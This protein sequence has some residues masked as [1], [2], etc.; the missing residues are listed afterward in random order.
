LCALLSSGGGAEA[1]VLTGGTPPQTYA[2]PGEQFTALAA[3]LFTYSKTDLT[4]AGPMPISVTRVYRSEDKDASGNFVAR[5][6]GL[7]TRLNYNLFLY[8]NSE[9]AYGIYTDAQVI[10]P[11]GARISCQRTSAC[12][13]SS[14]T[15][16][17]NAIFTCA[18]QPTG[19][20]FG[21][22]ISYNAATPG[23]DLERKDGTV[24]AFGLGAPLQS[25]ADRYGNQL[26]ITH[27]SGQSGKI[28]RVDSSNG[29]YVT[30]AY[31]DA[32]NPNAIT[33][34][35]DNSGRTVQYDYNL[36][37]KLKHAIYASF[38]SN[39]STEYEW[40][41]APKEGDIRTIILNV[42]GPTGSIAKNFNYIT[43]QTSGRLASVSSQL[44][45]SGYQYSYFG[46]TYVS[47]VNVTLPDNSV[48][49]LLF[50]S[51]G[52]VTDDR[53]AF[54]LSIQ[55]NTSYIRNANNLVTSMTDPLG[56]QTSY[57][58]DG[59]GNVTSVTHTP[60]PGTTPSATTTYTYEPAF[61]RVASI[62]APLTPPTTMSYN[63]ASNPTSAT[64]TDPVGRTTTL[65]Y[66]ASGQVASV[67]DPLGNT[68]I[69]T[70]DLTSGDQRTVTDPLGN[71]T[72]S[73]TDSV[74][75]VTSVTT[76]LG[77]TTQYAYDALDHVTSVTDP[78]GKVTSYEYI[79]L[80]DLSKVTDARGNVTTITVGA[81]LDVTTVCDA[82][83]HC[84]TENRNAM[85]RKTN[86]FDKRNVKTLYNYDKLGRVT[87]VVHN[88][89]GIAQYDQ[90]TISYAYDAGD[91]ATSIGDTGGG[92]TS[93]QTTF[94][95]DGMDNVLSVIT[96]EGTITYTYDA[97]GR[98]TTMTSPSSQGSGNQTLTYT[99]YNDDQLQSISR[100]GLSASLVLDA[101]GRRATLSVNNVT[102][103]YGYDNASRLTSLA[104][105]A[106][107]N[108]LGNLAYTYDNDSQITA[109]GGALAR[110][111]LPATSA[112]S[113]ANTNQLS[114]WS[115]V[116]VTSDNANNLTS[117]PTTS[118]TYK[119]D[120][121][122]MMSQVSSPL[123][124]FGYD[125]VGRRRA[126]TASSTTSTYLYDDASAIR[127]VTGSGGS[128]VKKDVLRMPGSG[129]V[130][131]YSSTSGSTTTTWTPIH[132]QIGSTV[133]LVDASGAMATQYTY[134][135]FGRTTFGGA[136]NSFAFQYTGMEFDSGTELYH[137]PA[138]YY[139]PKLHRFLSEDPVGV[140]GGDANLFSYAKNS[141][142]NFT[143]PTGMDPIVIPTIYVVYTL[144]ALSAGVGAWWDPLGIFTGGGEVEIPREQQHKA[145]TS[146]GLLRTGVAWDVIPSQAQA[147]Q[148]PDNGPLLENPSDPEISR[149]P[150]EPPGCNLSR[151]D[152]AQLKR[153]MG[154]AAQIPGFTVGMLAAGTVGTLT[155][156]PT[157]II[158]AGV[159]GYTAGAAAG[160]YF[161]WRSFMARHNCG[162]FSP[163]IMQQY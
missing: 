139:S 102:T 150:M 21:S 30:F 92:G 140:G 65:T 110:T 159:G 10:M 42:K 33:S 90:R 86:Y 116:T 94:T 156:N 105:A 16:Y 143:D 51:A 131:A 54:G 99:Y 63:D 132:D 66:N 134:E 74:G 31:G 45:D 114:W 71:Q 5:D 25:I 133:A 24:Y 4:V 127:V 161:A 50:N 22:T 59:L 68:S 81:T 112:A 107:G 125:A 120:S 138:R 163:S 26:T 111:N 135:P 15:D 8:S 70:Y 47:Q 147:N 78:D 91:R 23:W 52:Y 153:E 121:R 152:I 67:Q 61:N 126:M 80:G 3:G 146:R 32:S 2:A 130:L 76:P 18:S 12:N 57:T 6:F 55:E 124:T 13:P 148:A 108:P 85:G 14:C 37:A 137:T 136:S 157:A 62:D 89:T 53:R 162:P 95:Y 1:Y 46:S 7:G 35:T 44:P 117:N 9:V 144:A 41:A 103:T 128:A 93:P 43:Y 142:L 158:S 11:D 29:R 160:S 77:N 87:S 115:G 145:H 96:P 36:N 69:F 39:A 97:N 79:L 75:R 104:Y 122:S 100:P 49:S 82:A 72:T 129:E 101:A 151:E 106:N 20:W 84:A 154:A 149:Q 73:A 28:T 19:V 155:K 109:T 83:N 64:I 119:W 17:A 58:Y 60:G 123:T 98:R 88:S 118:A 38:N 48:R 141:P 34:A 27:S 56:R 40:E 113:Y